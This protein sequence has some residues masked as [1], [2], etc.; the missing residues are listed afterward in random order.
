MAKLGIKYLAVAVGT[1]T[2]SA[3]S[4]AS[5]TVFMLPISADIAINTAKVD[6]YAGDVLAETDRSFI[7]GTIKLK[8][9]N[10]A[11]SLK[12]LVLGYAEGADADV[13]ISSKELSAGNATTPPI[14]GVGLYGKV[15]KS[16]V[17]SWR[18]VWLKKITFSEPSDTFETKG[19]SA[20]FLTPELDGTIMM[21]AD[22]LWKE[23][24]RFSTEALAAAWL[25]AKVGI[26]S[27]A[28]TGLT[29]LA[30][31]NGTITP[32]FSATKYNYNCVATGD[33]AITATA[34]GII[35]LYVDGVYNQTL[36]TTVAGV[37]VVVGAGASKLF[38]I[39]VQESGKSAKT[40]QIVVQR[41]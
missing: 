5:G 7:S 15:V 22:G 38:T 33:V 27:A 6:L 32:T 36:T 17:F 16:G 29:A 19:E 4:Y 18:A 28:S 14:V 37:A 34:A 31:S 30:A 8:G 24:A 1:E 3:I 12:V 2:T 11:D 25:N 40:T 9:D 13:T 26:S 35:K 21:A 20:A 23:E 39:V 10:L 41:A